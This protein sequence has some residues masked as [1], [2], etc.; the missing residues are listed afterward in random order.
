MANP[1]VWILISREQ[2]RK[3]AEE[4]GNEGFSIQGWIMK[5]GWWTKGQSQEW[6][7]LVWA[8]QVLCGLL[9]ISRSARYIVLLLSLHLANLITHSSY[10]PAWATPLFHWPEHSLL[11]KDS[12]PVWAAGHTCMPHTSQIPSSCCRCLHYPGK[13]Y[14]AIGSRIHSPPLSP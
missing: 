4:R 7:R 6:K 11:R 5:E 10:Y 8:Q 13:P 12:K 9:Q 14:T 3:T 2:E 1:E